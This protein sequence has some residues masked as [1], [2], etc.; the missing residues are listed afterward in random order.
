M[1]TDLSFLERGKP[2]PPLCEA[3][4][5]ETYAAHKELFENKH[6]K[7]YRQQMRRIDRVIGNFSEVINYPVILAYQR[8]M[9]LKM[10]DLVIGEPPSITVPD[11]TARA[12]TVDLEKQQAV[13][14]FLADTELMRKVYSGIID[15]S[16]YG[17]A[18]LVLGKKDNAVPVV[19]LV[20]PRPWF[21]VVDPVS[22]DQTHYHVLAYDWLA[23]KSRAEYRLSMEVHK[24]D[25]PGECE[26]RTYM[27][28]GPPGAWRIGKEVSPKG[29]QKVERLETGIDVCPVFV[30]SNVQT[31]DSVYG[32]DDYDSLDSIISEM[33][34]RVAQI[35]RVLDKHAA[36]SM[37]GPASALEK[38][39]VTGQWQLRLAEY[40]ARENNDDPAPE[41]I[42]W[43]GNLDA[44]FKHLEVLTNQLYIISEMGAAIF[45][46]AAN[47]TGA[48]PS[49]SA[50]RRLMI[51]P[52][53]KARRV[54]AG[55]DPVLKRLVSAGTALYGVEISPEEITIKWND[56]LPDDEAEQAQIMDIR[57]GRQPTISQYT[58]IQRMDNMSPEDIE[59]EL[60]QM[61]EEAAG[62]TP[63]VLSSIEVREDA[64][65][66]LPAPEDSG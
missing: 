58:A 29:T 23:D 15:L 60:E 27:L 7:V 30:L 59:S 28:E 48:V 40:F 18:L 61:R 65:G 46:D 50:L 51:S 63:P 19:K 38:D 47:K 20:P 57:T 55:I 4:R 39:Q 14:R 11:I 44:A 33:L 8:L 5:L 10:A 35:S 42:T 31:S 3:E 17:N 62:R 26:E 41:Y 43:D 66:N 16:R 1:L 25:A 6:A 34:I 13:D 22:I 32:L 9:S 56:G 49:G 24:V 45:G 12:G 2:W 37:S 64:S 52:L 21:P 53:A 54:A 36:P